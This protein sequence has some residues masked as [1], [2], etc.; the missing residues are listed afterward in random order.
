MSQENKIDDGGNAFPLPV[1]A[2]EHGMFQTRDEGMT[3]RDYFAAKAMQSLI[4]EGVGYNSDPGQILAMT[5][6][7]FDWADAML[8]ARKSGETGNCHDAP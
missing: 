6:T 1:V 3:M 4:I 8:K 2:N 5:L 7:A